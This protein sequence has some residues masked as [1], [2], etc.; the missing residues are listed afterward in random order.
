MPKDNELRMRWPTAII[1]LCA[2][3]I[4]ILWSGLTLEMLRLKNAA[5]AQAQND[6]KNLAATFQADVEGR[7]TGSTG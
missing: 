1:V 3:F 2:A 7:C 5:I 4:A 6:A